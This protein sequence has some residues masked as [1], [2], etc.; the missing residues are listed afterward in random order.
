M[1]T[2][3]EL[4]PLTPAQTREVLRRLGD[5]TEQLVL[6]GGQALAFWAER[7]ADRFTIS[8]PVNSKDIDFFMDSL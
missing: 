4:P 6:I 7:Y 3:A 8:G 2:E 1:T 5:L